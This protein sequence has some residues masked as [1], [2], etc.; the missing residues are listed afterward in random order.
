MVIMPKDERT[1]GPRQR[2]VS[3]RFCRV[4]KLRCDREA[5]CSSCVS[6]GIRCD[7][8]QHTS[9]SPHG[10]GTTEIELLERI[11]KLEEAIRDQGDRHIESLKQ[12]PASNNDHTEKA[13]TLNPS[14]EIKGLDSDAAWLTSFCT[15]SY[16]SV[17]LFLDQ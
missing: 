1:H 6:R 14:T 10:I 12:D 8:V 7:L 5:P 3:C 11:R 17:I 2:P 13:Y 16:I 4:R 15:D 9:S